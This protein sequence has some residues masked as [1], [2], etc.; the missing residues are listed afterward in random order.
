MIELTRRP[1]AHAQR[2]ELIVG[3][4]RAVEEQRIH[5]RK[6]VH[7]RIV[8]A[9][10]NLLSPDEQDVLAQASVFR[11]GFSAPAARAVLALPDGASPVPL[12][13]RAR[14]LVLLRAE[15]SHEFPDQLRFWLLESVRDFAGRVLDR[16]G[17]RAEAER[18]HADHYLERAAEWSRDLD[19]RLS[20]VGDGQRSALTPSSSRRR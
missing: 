11:G 6:T 9:S 19:G 15:P 14:E 10:W 17:G 18:R 4:E 8:E 13:T 7:E 1:G 20:N 12:L 5:V 3:P 2:H 16:A